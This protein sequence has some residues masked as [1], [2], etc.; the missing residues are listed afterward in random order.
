MA[1]I[2]QKCS[3]G[4]V[5]GFRCTGCR[6]E[7]GGTLL[8]ELLEFALLLPMSLL[9]GQARADVANNQDAAKENA[10]AVVNR[11]IIDAGM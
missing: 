3:F 1:D 11:R 2:G 10:V 5:G 7:R 9:A 4:V 6:S 8:N